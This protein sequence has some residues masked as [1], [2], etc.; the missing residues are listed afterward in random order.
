ME[1]HHNLNDSV[2]KFD[3][4]LTNFKV[5]AHVETMNFD[6]IQ[7]IYQVNNKTILVIDSLGI[8]HLMLP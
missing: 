6:T 8:Y 4:T 2:F 3:K 5:G 1:V 7:N